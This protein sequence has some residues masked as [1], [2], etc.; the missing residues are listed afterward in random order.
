MSNPASRS[1]LWFQRLSV[2]TLIFAFS[3][4]TLGALTRLKDAGL[5]CPDWPGCYGQ[6]LVPSG[7]GAAEQAAASHPERPLEVVKAWYEMIH[8][9]LAG[10]LG[11]LILGL[12]L[13]RFAL[14]A[15]TKKQVGSIP[16][17]LLGLVIFQALLGA[18]TV[19]MGLFPTVVMGHLLGGFTTFTL[20][21]L[22]VFK[23]KLP[24]L[25]MLQFMPKH[26]KKMLFIGTLV[27]ITQVALGGW[28]AAN[29]AAAVCTELP[30]CNAGWQEH[31]NLKSAFQLW[32]HNTADYEFAP[33][34]GT[35]TKITIHVTHRIGA[36][37][38]TLVLSILIFSL[39]KTQNIL[40]KKMALLIAGLLSIQMLLGISNVVFNVPLTIAVLHNLVGCLLFATLV[41]LSLFSRTETQPSKKVAPPQPKP[42]LQPLNAQ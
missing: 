22:L 24:A 7:P 18:W 21:A 38:T 14:P 10:T 29:Y 26:L 1:Q 8:R 17:L 15:K 30:I 11:L 27:T 31:I 2:F 13:F 16:L 37:I 36:A 42:M 39:W 41:N 5:G 32:G 35:D 28:T 3:V 6:L 9:Y 12:F 40:L 25:K 20:L 33:H 34:L 4:V 19:T 23:Q